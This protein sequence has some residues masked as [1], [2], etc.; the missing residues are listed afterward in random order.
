LPKTISAV[1]ICWWHAYPG[2]VYQPVDLTVLFDY[3][4]NYL[5]KRTVISYIANL[6]SI[7]V[8]RRVISDI[9]AIHMCTGPR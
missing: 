8:V 5:L 3:Q 1:A 2:I 6:R 9:E 7:R 4:P